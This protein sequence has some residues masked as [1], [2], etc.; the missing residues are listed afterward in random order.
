MNE[1]PLRA[2]NSPFNAEQ[3]QQ[4]SRL[5]PTLTDEQLIWLGGYLAGVRS[6]P[7]QQPAGAATFAATAQPAGGG[8]PAAAS[9]TGVT[10][11]FASQTGNAMRLAGELSQRLEHAGLSVTLSCMS[12]Y[13]TSALK[14]TRCLLIVASTHGEGE[15]PDK[16]RLFHEFLH[17]KRAPRLEGLRYS[18]LALGDLSYKQFCQI[19]KDFDRQLEALG[20]Q[21]LHARVDC[22]VDYREAAEAWMLAVWQVLAGEVSTASASGAQAGGAMPSLSAPSR[23][24]AP[25]S[26]D[27]YSREHPFHAEVLESFTLNGRGSDKETRFMKL[28]LEPSGLSFEPGDSLGIF[29]QNHPSLVDDFIAEMRWNADELVPAGK[30]EMPLREALLKR[31]EITRLT[32]PLLQQAAEFSRDG[33]HELVHRRSDDELDAY[34]AGRDL[35]DLA[36]DFSLVGIPPRDFVR[37]L[38]RI[39]A[40]LY[41]ISSSYQATPGEVDLTISVLRYHAHKRDRLGACSSYCAERVRLGD[42]VPVYVSA[43]PN[44]RMPTDPGVPIIMVGA[45]TGVAPFRAFLEQREEAGAASR[46]WLFFGDRRFR[47]DFLYQLDWLRWRKQGVLTRMDVAFSRDASAK[48][49]VQHR[50]LQRSREIYAWLQEGACFYVCG[51]EKR[52]APDVHAALTAIVRQEGGMSDE[53]AKDY[54]DVLRQQNRYQRDV[55]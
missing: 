36:R 25:R 30:E 33:L 45:G 8:A 53:Q 3:A 7:A 28:S 14:K 51:D 54:L 29:P 2:E 39:P 52:M 18:V 32:R 13:R 24:F 23:T 43:N 6:R 37:S 48:V 42:R 20:A 50:M 55:Y 17:G 11:L 10:V 26:V 40:R 31:Y 38:R 46:A 27:A 41:S 44:F 5:I 49:Y 47:T 22:D 15:P 34:V 21:R 4:L 9:G 1:P 19:G 35:I 16:A 12:E